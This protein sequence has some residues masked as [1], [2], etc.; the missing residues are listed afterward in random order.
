MFVYTLAL[1][2][3]TLGPW[4]DQTRTI[5]SLNFCPTNLRKKWKKKQFI[6]WKSFQKFLFLNIYRCTFCYSVSEM[7]ACQHKNRNIEYWILLNIDHLNYLKK[8]FLL[9]FEQY[10][11]LLV[12]LVLHILR[13]MEL[14]CTQGYE[15][16][17]F[18]GH[19][20]IL[21]NGP[22][23][24]FNLYMVIN[25]ESDHQ[26]NSATEAQLCVKESTEPMYGYI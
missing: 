23:Q 18:K 22:S 25:F 1:C 13:H 7:Q 15:V 5:R 12:K 10:F 3:D 17:T 21:K 14:V 19:F 20:M 9:W 2:G 8:S 6:Y 11:A 24:F 16:I 4:W 26:M